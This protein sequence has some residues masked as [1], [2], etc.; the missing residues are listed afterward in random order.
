MLTLILADA[1]IE[2]VP[3]ELARHP[4]VRGHSRR[5]EKRA[6]WLLLDSSLHHKA[7]EALPDGERRGRPDIVHLFLL[8][9]LDSV[10]NLEGRLRV[11]VHTRDDMLITVHPSTRIIRNY[12]RFIGLMEQL[13]HVGRVPYKGEAL[14]TLEKDVKLA[15]AVERAKSDRVVVLAEDGKRV[16]IH[17]FVDEV[18]ASSENPCVIIGGF[19]KGDFRS[20]VAGLGAD[21]VS[22]H[23]TALSAW[24]AAGEWIVNWERVAL[25]EPGN[26]AGPAA[27]A[28][29]ALK[30]S[31]LA[32]ERL[33]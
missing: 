6:E 10:L 1:E 12:N 31:G 11:L 14:M 13:F 30:G 20:D 29:G 33:R 4:S 21:R 2:R 3:K 23:P 27:R 22:I 16:R 24:V 19:P 17:E 26:E 28:K 8:T 18:G 15:T 7:L 25:E 5:T 32:R 9:A